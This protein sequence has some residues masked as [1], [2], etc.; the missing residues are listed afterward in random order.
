VTKPRRASGTMTMLEA[1]MWLVAR[2]RRYDDD[3]R[4][5]AAGI[6]VTVVAR[7][8]DPVRG[9]RGVRGELVL[10]RD[11]VEWR[12]R[13]SD[14]V[15]VPHGTVAERRRTRDRMFRSLRVDNGPK[16]YVYVV[17]ARDVRLVTEVLSR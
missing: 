11:G 8:R 1:G 3:V 6:P 13:R 15:P 16:A 5:L 10:T 14:A 12:P 4:D 17:P 9:G 7:R 2:G